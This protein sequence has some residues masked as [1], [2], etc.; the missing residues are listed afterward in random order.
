MELREH[1][2]ETK[3]AQNFAHPRPS[4]SLPSLLHRC[5]THVQQIRASAY[6]RLHNALRRSLNLPQL[7]SKQQQHP[8][9]RHNQ[10]PF[11]P[12]ADP[13]PQDYHT[14][15]ANVTEDLKLASEA[16]IELRAVV[17]AWPASGVPPVSPVDVTTAVRWIDML[18]QLEEKKLVATVSLHAMQR[19]A[20][21]PNHADDDPQHVKQRMTEFARQ[22][23]GTDQAINELLGEILEFYTD[24]I[25]NVNKT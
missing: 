22:L 5:I 11:I 7:H 16:V 20:S 15:C 13:P 18:Q 12:H 14:V 2:S 9:P 10:Q 25:E 17:D 1:P 4:E 3:L 21:Q 8:L 23:N 19:S 6:T 24:A